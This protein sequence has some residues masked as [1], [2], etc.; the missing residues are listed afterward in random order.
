MSTADRL[1]FKK[2][3]IHKNT[4]FHKK[5]I[6]FHC[7]KL[8]EAKASRKIHRS[9]LSCAVKTYVKGGYV[10]VLISFH[11]VERILKGSLD[12]IPST[13]PLAKIQIMGGKVCFWCKGKTLLGVVKKLLKTKTLLTSPSNIL[14]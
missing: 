6:S 9:I 1:P 11:K 13:S 8:A 4:D 14:P 12:S 3:Q 5:K 10:G 2:I 7:V